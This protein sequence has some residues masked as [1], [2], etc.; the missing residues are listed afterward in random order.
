VTNTGTDNLVIRFGLNNGIFG[1]QMVY[2][3]GID[4]H[5]Q[6]VITTDINKDNQLDIVTVNSKNNSISMI[7][8]Y[9]NGTFAAMRTYSTGIGS[10]PIFVSVLV[11]LIMTTD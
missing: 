11:I 7:M 3:I 10:G 8:G 1:T 6:Y 5:P 4:S 9:G 2:P